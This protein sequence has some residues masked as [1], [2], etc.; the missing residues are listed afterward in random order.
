MKS[1]HEA[2]IGLLMTIAR[3]KKMDSQ[4][5]AERGVTGLQ[6]NFSINMFCIKG[7][8]YVWKRSISIAA[9]QG[10]Q[11]VLVCLFA[12]IAHLDPNKSLTTIHL[13]LRPDFCCWTRKAPLIRYCVRLS[14]HVEWPEKSPKGR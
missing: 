2:Q 4:S 10:Q 9:C 11:I 12:L 14:S 7:L 8:S 5:D 6:A 1:E 3:E 13:V